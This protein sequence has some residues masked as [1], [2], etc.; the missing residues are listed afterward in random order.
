MAVG[1]LARVGV[2][3]AIAVRPEAT[4][5]TFAV[6]TTSL[7]CYA[8]TS[9]GIQSS[10]ET[11]KLDELTGGRGYARQVQKD[12][13]VTGGIEGYLHPEESLPFLINAMGG[14]YT[15]NS[16]TSAGDHSITTGN[17]SASDTVVSISMWAQKGEQHFWRYAGGVINSLKIRASINEPVK[18]SA[19]FVFQESSI[20]TADT[21]M[22]L[23]LSISSARPFIYVDGVYRY[24]ATE[25]SLTS[26]VN[27]P[28]QSFEL[29]INNNLITDAQAR[30]LG[31][32]ILSRIPP[33][34]RRDVT[35]KISQRF[36]TTTTYGRMVDNTAGAVS[37]FFRGESISAEFFKDLTIFLPNVRMKNTEPLVEGA[38]EVLKSEIELDVLISGNP[39]TS[40]SREIG[41]TVRNARTTA[42]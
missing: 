7:N 4:Y 28:I 32:R 36:D 27:E 6:T 29:E 18:M 9:I 10:Y 34:P 25:G 37:L 30:Q 3:S 31:T 40:T 26:S 20:S 41:M 39:G 38:N 24:D 1:D 21:A 22:A 17:F 35:L 16:L 23:V 15:F 12:K 33:S 8:P 42:Y 5:G 2:R 14:R 11:E 13:S 19:E